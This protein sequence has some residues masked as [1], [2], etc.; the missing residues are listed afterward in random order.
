MDSIVRNDHILREGKIF[1]KD[2][3][4]NYLPGDMHNCRCHMEEVP[5]YILIKDEAT[6]NKAFKLYICTGKRHSILFIK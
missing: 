5:D 4:P 6:V 1:R 2:N 3:P